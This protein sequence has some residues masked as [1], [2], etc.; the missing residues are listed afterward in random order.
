MLAALIWWAVLLSRYN[1]QVYHQSEGG[2]SMDEGT[3]IRKQRMIIGEA[4]IF[5]LALVTGIGLIYR[6][7]VDSVKAERR[8]TNF[9]LSITHELRSPLA[10][11]SLNVETVKR[12]ISPSNTLVDKSLGFVESETKRLH[13][14][15]ENLLQSVNSDNV[16]DAEM[17][18]INLPELLNGVHLTYFPKSN[19]EIKPTSNDI[20][21]FANRQHIISIFQNLIDNA[22]KYS[23]KG[24]KVDVQI[25]DS[26]QSVIT[27]VIDQA[28]ILSTR[29]ISQIFDQFVR[30]GSEETRETKG[31]GLGLSIVK[32]LI[33]SYSGTIDVTPHAT[34][35]IFTVTLPKDIRA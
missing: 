18:S 7:Y 28:P 14:L 21:I 22:I 25:S 6:G 27:K 13:R 29:D 20:I 4:C 5:G 8:K 17:Q 34:G 19:I 26:P 31:V 30:L 12:L 35:N 1:K 3:Y 9:L 33:K 15:I 16:Q 32:R 11:I 23:P 24:S 2:I 10:G